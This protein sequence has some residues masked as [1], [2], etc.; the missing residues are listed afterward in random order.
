[1]S[2][3]LSCGCVGRLNGAI[4]PVMRSVETGAPE[5]IMSHARQLAEQAVRL[6]ELRG[7]LQTAAR[8]LREVW[9]AG[10]KSADTQRKLAELLGRFDNMISLLSGTA[11][12]LTS[13]A[14]V[15]QRSRVAFAKG[16][17][18]GDAR[19]IPLLAAAAA[20]KP[21]A[22]AKA[23]ITAAQTTISLRGIIN[24]FAE[25]LKGLGLQ[26]AGTIL[27]KVAEIAG[28]L[29][30]LFEHNSAQ[31]GE[32]NGAGQLPGPTPGPT[33]VPPPGQNPS[34]APSPEPAPTPLPL[35]V[36]ADA[37]SRIP[38]AITNYRPPALFPTPGG[39]PGSDLSWIPVD[40]PGPGAAA[41]RVEVTVTTKD[42][43][44]TTVRAMPG[45]DAVF[46]MKVGADQVRVA[47]DG[48]ADGR[49]TA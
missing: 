3:A 41:G 13:A 15:I 46:D 17:A 29:Q 26:E 4:F 14:D 7:R 38:D 43:A 16:I 10:G 20:G 40:Q 48:D 12:V 27:S 8:D 23:K 39:T 30:E 9:P 6:Q 35:P 19:I 32:N 34:P 21:G 1:M 42:G 37:A 2:G 18:A 11:E 49:V 28:L 31:A 25:I 44:T 45:Q 33:P 47:I 24:G 22:M 5:R 36:G